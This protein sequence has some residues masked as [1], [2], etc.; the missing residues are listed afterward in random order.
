MS[1]SKDK[2]PSVPLIGSTIVSTPPRTNETTNFYASLQD[3]PSVDSKSTLNP[4]DDSHYESAGEGSV[5]LTP[6]ISNKTDTNSP[7]SSESKVI[8][9]PVSPKESIRRSA[10][11]SPADPIAAILPSDMERHRLDGPIYASDLEKVSANIF[12]TEDEKIWS[13]SELHRS[14]NR[15][16]NTK[17]KQRK[18]KSTKSKTLVQI[19][20]D[21]GKEIFPGKKD[22]SSSQ[23]SI[24][25]MQILAE[26]LFGSDAK[27][28]ARVNPYNSAARNPENR[29][30][31]DPSELAAVIKVTT[32]PLPPSADQ[33]QKLTCYDDLKPA[34][35]QKKPPVGSL[36]PPSAASGDS[37][38]AKDVEMIDSSAPDPLELLNQRIERNRQQLRE[39]ELTLQR[40]KS[41]N[42]SSQEMLA[43]VEN[44]VREE[45]EATTEPI[46]DSESQARKKTVPRGHHY[47]GSRSAE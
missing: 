13:D 40:F 37:D 4:D 34:A 17:N 21:Q 8:L 31:P 1:A 11:K 47:K 2:D 44:T 23:D 30:Y 41:S 24:E 43:E 5:I 38:K 25:N 32:K 35:T 6:N 7:Q 39:M 16:K 14:P 10:I 29:F 18:F 22:D 12:E 46:R 19:F 27:P 20:N 45:L 26:Q 15:K 28:K 9:N 3:D 42:K 33:S 36:P